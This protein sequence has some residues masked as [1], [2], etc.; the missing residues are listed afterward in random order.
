[1]RNKLQTLHARSL[2]CLIETTFLAPCIHWVS[3]VH[4]RV[5]SCLSYQKKNYLSIYLSI[6]LGLQNILS[7]LP[8]DVGDIVPR[9]EKDQSDLVTLS[10]LEEMLNSINSFF[11]L[12]F[13]YLFSISY[14]FVL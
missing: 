3:S 12:L 5:S 14:L 1:M 11:C 4:E 7:I 6:Y 2:H 8:S 9:A 10:L 13:I